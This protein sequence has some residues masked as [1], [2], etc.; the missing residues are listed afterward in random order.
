MP[1]IIPANHHGK[2]IVEPQRLGHL[3]AKALAVGLPDA[4]VHR[5]SLA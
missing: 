5:C 1:R 2:G 4:I 3:E